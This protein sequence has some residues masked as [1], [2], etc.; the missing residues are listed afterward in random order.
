MAEINLNEIIEKAKELAQTASEKSQEFYQ[1]SKLKIEIGELK[2][3][4][5]KNFNAIGKQVYD[6]KKA[7]EEL[8]SFDALV[9]EID[10]LNADIEEKKDA[11]SE[12]KNSKRC[13]NCGA[14][15]SEDD[16]F[17]AKCGT[18]VK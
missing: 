18:S 17:C 12:I 8:P 2:L 4:R 5:D 15:I 1:I 14:D 10:L 11:I 16:P 13:P 7:G 9:E 3:K 6:A